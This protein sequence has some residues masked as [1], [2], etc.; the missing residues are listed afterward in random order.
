MLRRWADNLTR[1]HGPGAVDRVRARIG[2]W[3]VPTDP[4]PGDPVR[5][6][7]HLRLIEAIADELHDE[8]LHRIA[9][10]VRE[11]V[12]RDIP[13]AG[14]LA[15]RAYGAKRALRH[16]PEA[17]RKLYGVGEVRAES[18]RG[19]AELEYANAPLFGHPTWRFVVLTALG[20]AVEGGAGRP[21]ARAAF[22]GDEARFRVALEW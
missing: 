14:R 19:R 21:P 4:Q 7:A 1:R 18:A 20:I 17:H 2:D 9:H 15:M 12:Q 10:N 13:R 22:D 11:D 8:D 5:V 3:E 16:V 6:A